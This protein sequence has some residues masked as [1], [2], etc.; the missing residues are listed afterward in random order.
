MAI[1]H[2]TENIIKER[3]IYIHNNVWRVCGYHILIKFFFDIQKQF[4][5]PASLKADKQIRHIVDVRVL[6]V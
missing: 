5:E 6:C 4:Q 2:Q 3:Y 1:F